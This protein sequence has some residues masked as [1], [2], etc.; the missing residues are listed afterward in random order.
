[1]GRRPRSV[2]N[3]QGQ[4]SS[5]PAGAPPFHQPT[6]ALSRRPIMAGLPAARIAGPCFAFGE[7]GHILIHC[8]KMTALGA[9][10][11]RKWYPFEGG[12]EGSV[13]EGVRMEIVGGRVC[14]D[15]ELYGR[16]GVGSGS[17]TEAVGHSLPEE[18]LPVSLS[19]LFKEELGV[20]TTLTPLIR[21]TCGDVGSPL[22]ITDTCSV[23]VPHE[24]IEVTNS[25]GLPKNMPESGGH[26]N[27]PDSVKGRLQERLSFWKEE[28]QASSFVLRTIE[29]GYVL[30]LKSE[31]TPLSRRNQQSALRNAKFV[32]ESIA[33][34]VATRCV[35][36]VPEPPLVCS[37][38]SVVENSVG[39][40]RLVVNLKHFNRFLWKQK[41]KY[42][43]LRIAMI[44][45]I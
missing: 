25:V 19:P 21:N 40:K 24:A 29:S 10:G 3:P 4:V 44:A 34:L 43:D 33:D 16:D 18:D 28:L 39:K 6:T 45:V 27:A 13:L 7:M 30:P 42:E 26:V 8:H 31:P 9:E 36:V 15:A 23:V 20:T 5:A 38:L 12:G 32:N 2:R 37:P 35:R 22:A 17:T 14:T 11:T 41:F 1:M